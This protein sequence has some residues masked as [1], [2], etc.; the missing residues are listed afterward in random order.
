MCAS[1][2]KAHFVSSRAGF[3]MGSDLG[4]GGSGKR[5]AASCCLRRFPHCRQQ[6]AALQKSKR[7][8]AQGQGRNE[9]AV[10]VSV[11]CRGCN[12][13]AS[14]RRPGENSSQETPQEASSP[15]DKPAPQ[16]AGTL[17]RPKAAMTVGY[18]GTAT[19]VPFRLQGA[20]RSECRCA[21]V[22]FRFADH[23]SRMPRPPGAEPGGN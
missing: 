22:N 1:Q 7:A 13:A 21:T 9:E 15:Q 16:H 14:S 2:V 6:P 12:D 3:C 10:A 20:R 11:Y 18:K 8:R 19:A 17:R 23:A 5:G 4:L